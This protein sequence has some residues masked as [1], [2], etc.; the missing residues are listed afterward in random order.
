MDKVESVSGLRNPANEDLPDLASMGAAVGRRDLFVEV[1]AMENHG[2]TSAPHSHMPSANVLK[3]V[4]DTL[5]N[6]P[7]GNAPIA[8]H[9]DVGPTLGAAYRAALQASG[10]DRYIIAGTAPPAA[11]QSRRS[12]IRGSRQRRDT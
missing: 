6:P 10:A 7:S 8:V 5:A 4:G 3:L 11:R 12:C 1:G 9:F 2:A